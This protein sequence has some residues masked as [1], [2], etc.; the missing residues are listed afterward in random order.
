MFRTA[1][2]ATVV[3]VSIMA[4]MAQAPL[5]IMHL[6][7]NGTWD[8]RLVS[9]DTRYVLYG[10]PFQEG[11]NDSPQL[12]LQESSSDRKQLLMKLSRTLSAQW[13]PDS[14]AFSINNEFSS[15]TTNAFIY[16]VRT[17]ERI[18]VGERILAVDPAAKRF[19]NGH[20]YFDIESWPDTKHVIVRFH[21]HVES[22][23]PV[24]CFDSRYN[25]SRDGAVTKLSE[26]SGTP[27]RVPCS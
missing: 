25:V 20:S 7:T 1:R 6:P 24:I 17:L 14:S 26:Q 22:E 23:S 2:F 11:V 21:G 8:T 10:V 9:P 18:S 27:G 16:D 3:W 4:C 15:D 13:A 12:W 19:S 5:N